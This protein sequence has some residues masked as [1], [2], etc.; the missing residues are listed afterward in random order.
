MSQLPN[1]KHIRSNVRQRSAV[2]VGA[3]SIL[4]GIYQLGIG[5]RQR[6]LRRVEAG[7][8]AM[9]G[10]FLLLKS[11]VVKGDGVRWGEIGRRVGALIDILSR[12]QQMRGSGGHKQKGLGSRQQKVGDED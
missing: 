5:F 12:T 3:L 7:L 11:G 9:G 1:N 6:N 2:G 4:F 8:E 10:G